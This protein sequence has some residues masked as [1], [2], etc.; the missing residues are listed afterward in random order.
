MY[1]RKI[2]ILALI[3][4]G[5]SVLLDELLPSIVA[6]GSYAEHLYSVGVYD[7]GLG[8]YARQSALQEIA[9]RIAAS[10]QQ[11]RNAGDVQQAL[12]VA[13]QKIDQDIVDNHGYPFL[14]P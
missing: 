3:L 12:D 9:A 10:A 4:L 14:Q 8:L 1:L 2:P 5:F 6:Q 13:A 7:S 11:L